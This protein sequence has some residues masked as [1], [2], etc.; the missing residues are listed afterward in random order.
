MGVLTRA[1]KQEQWELAAYCLLVA[2]AKLA[3][4]VPPDTL[5]ELLLA[6]EQG[7]Y[8]PLQ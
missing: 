7:G 6:L 4:T 2:V 3:A 5:A 1:I 8:E